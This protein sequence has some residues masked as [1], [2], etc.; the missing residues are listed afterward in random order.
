LQQH[1]IQNQY[2]ETSQKV[3]TVTGGL[4]PLR[5]ARMPIQV[6]S[7]QVKM[8]KI[9]LKSAPLWQFPSYRGNLSCEC[10]QGSEPPRGCVVWRRWCRDSQRP[11]ER[12]AV[13]VAFTRCSVSVLRGNLQRYETANNHKEESSTIWATFP[14]GLCASSRHHPVLAAAL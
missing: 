3:R 12:R 13:L 6:K 5:G 10:N 8:L 11:L 14:N 7:S 4:A 2:V 1:T 9:K